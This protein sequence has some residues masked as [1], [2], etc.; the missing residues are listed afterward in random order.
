[1]Q[2]VPL[3]QSPK[4]SLTIALGSREFGLLV[5][6]NTVM[7]SWYLDAT[8]A[9]GTPLVTGRRLVCGWPFRVGSAATN[10]MDEGDLLLVVD[11]TG[12]NADPQRESW[13]TTHRLLYLPASSLDGGA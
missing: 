2:V 5:R 11:V 12:R 9:D 3:V 8:A 13:G 10:G 4:Q 7:R 6:W 1:M